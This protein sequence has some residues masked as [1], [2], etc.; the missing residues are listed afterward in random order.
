MSPDY[1]MTQQVAHW[2]MGMGVEAPLAALGGVLGP[3]VV[4]LVMAIG[5][6]AVVEQRV[7]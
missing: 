1:S 5:I 4:L 7:R 3:V 6:A 2:L